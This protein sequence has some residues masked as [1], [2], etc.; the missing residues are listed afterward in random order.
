MIL[1]TTIT[2]EGEPIVLLHIGLQTGEIDFQA[3]QEYFK[4]NYQVISP[5]LR[6]HGKS[7]SN[8]FSNFLQDSVQDLKDTLVNL[9]VETS[10][11]IG[12]SLGALVGLMFAKQFPENVKSLTISGIIPEKPADWEELSAED[13]KQQAQIL[14]N[15]EAVAYFDSIH[16][17]NWREI[18]EISNHT[19]WYPFHETEDLST[20][21]MPVLFIVGEGS[22]IETTGA[23]TYPKSNKNIHVSIIPFAG[24]N[25]HLEQPEIH[26]KIVENFLSEIEA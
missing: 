18:L 15:K 3:H 24:H 8:E 19:D 11:L 4:E 6:G 10:H 9:G 26:N 2:G 12:C 25:V 13:V 21:N 7:V 23:I 14:E 22:S 17:S 5:D 1:H 20:L 16:K